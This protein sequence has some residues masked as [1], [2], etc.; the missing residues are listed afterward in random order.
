LNAAEDLGHAFAAACPFPPGNQQ[1]SDVITVAVAELAPWSSWLPQAE[2]LLSGPEAQR[3][4]RQRRPSDRDGLILA[5][6]L[7]RLFL[8]RLLDLETTQVP[9]QRD[10]L[11]CPRLVGLPMETSLSHTSDAVAFAFSRSGPVGVDIEAGHR[12][13]VMAELAERICHHDEVAQLASLSTADRNTAL[14]RLWVRK[15]AYLKAAGVG[16]VCEMSEFA[17]P[18]GATL[19]LAIAAGHLPGEVQTKILAT[20]PGYLAAIAC[21]PGMPVQV[22]RLA[23]G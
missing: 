1:G 10:A 5:Y 9:L 16:L 7:H 13:E 11:G 17:A 15:E 22:W 19:E 23:P 21:T 20:L 2:E 4:A 6:A 18:E 14:L 8:A 12:A 3:A